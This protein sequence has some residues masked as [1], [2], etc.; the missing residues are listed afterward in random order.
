MLIHFLPGLI[1]FGSGSQ[2]VAWDGHHFMRRI[3]WEQLHNTSF[4]SWDILWLG[5]HEIWWRNS[6]GFLIQKSY[7]R[8]WECWEGPRWPQKRPVLQS[9][10]HFFTPF[11][12][13]LCDQQPSVSGSTPKDLSSALTFSWL[14][15]PSSMTHLGWAS[16]IEAM[17]KCV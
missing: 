4:I 1:H 3:H 16:I 17:W 14:R 9:A 6:L 10:S 7:I 11:C 2:Q 15:G 13:I 5:Y 12:M 8:Q